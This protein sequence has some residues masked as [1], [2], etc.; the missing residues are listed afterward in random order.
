MS[1]QKMCGIN[2]KCVSDFEY[3]STDWNCEFD[4]IK[5]TTGINEVISVSIAELY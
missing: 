3:L 5:F 1:F 2:P 4:Q